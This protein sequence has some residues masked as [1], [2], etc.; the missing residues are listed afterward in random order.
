MNSFVDAMNRFNDLYSAGYGPVDI[1][2]I[3]REEY[4]DMVDSVL[5]EAKDQGYI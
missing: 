3:L 1:M 2:L 4:P 5:Q